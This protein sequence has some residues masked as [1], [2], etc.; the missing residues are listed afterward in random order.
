MEMT[1]PPFYAQIK[2]CILIL[3]FFFI[4]FS[5]VKEKYLPM[6][7]LIIM[8]FM[9]GTHF[10]FIAKIRFQLLFT[11]FV[12]IMIVAKNKIAIIQNINPIHKMLML[13]FL[14]MFISV[15]QAF[16]MSASWDYFYR[17]GTQVIVFYLIIICFCNDK[18]DIRALLYC[19][20]FI[21]V[22]HAH[23]PIYNY[24]TG[25]YSFGHE[26]LGTGGIYHHVG[27]ILSGHVAIANA[28]TE[29]L[30]VAYFL[31]LYEKKILMKIICIIA[32]VLFLLGIFASGSR[33]GVIGL[34]VCSFLFFYKAKR[35]A[36]AGIIGFVLLVV[37]LGLNPQY[38]NWYSSILDGAGA[39]VS[40]SSRITGLRHGIEMCI[41]RPILGVGI[42]CYAYA[43]SAWFGW[44]IWAHNH[45][46]ELAGELGLA[47]LVAWV[48]FIVA[49][50]KMISRYQVKI[51]MRPDIDSLC[52]TILDICWCVLIV[53]LIIGMTTHSLF[54]FIWYMIGGMLVVVNR[55][56]DIR[57]VGHQQGDTIH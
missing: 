18:E 10:E 19:Y 37:F 6:A 52:K 1:F 56:S 40:A 9:P 26:R 33:G 21:M 30:P 8:S 16:S 45:Y 28:M 29:A 5:V 57:G 17:I 43:R 54:S 35:K 12:A 36:L 4:I 55:C 20:L 2:L 15:F 11:L 38:L 13:F 27:E 44:N 47:G 53:R 32:I 3:T 49:C 41:R 7:C 51:Q 23:L 50:F 46:G 39:D 42:G 14:V 24:L 31:F 22:W 48:G 25:T 34:A